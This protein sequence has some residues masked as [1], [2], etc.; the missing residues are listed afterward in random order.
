MPSL[1]YHPS[2]F[3]MVAVDTSI[4]KV[5]PG[6]T[7]SLQSALSGLPNQD[8]LVPPT[9][10]I[11]LLDAKNEIFLS[12]LQTLALRNL[13]VI[14]SVGKHIKHKSSSA[15]G[16]AKGVLDQSLDDQLVRDLVKHRVYLEKGVRP[17]EDRLKYQVDKVVR[18]ADD[19]ARAAQKA[20]SA[21]SSTTKKSSKTAQAAATGSDDSDSDSDPDSDEETG[22]A[23]IQANARSFM[24]VFT[25]PGAAT[26]AAP[27]T[28]ARQQ[29]MQEDGIY[30]PPRITATA[31]PTTEHK[32]AKEKRPMRSAT[33]DEY[34]A[35]ELSTA[36]AA[37]PSIGS[38]I[39]AGGRRDKS[40]RERKEEEERRV[41][42]ESNLV[43]LPKESKKDK[44]KKAHK[45]RGAYGGE[46]WRG[47]TD[48]VDR[49][50]RLTK[51]KIGSGGALERSRKRKAD[52]DGQRGDG[53]G[54]VDM[55]RD[56]ER[57]KKRT[58]RK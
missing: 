34:V 17:L 1:E 20:A 8:S 55:G 30:R 40:A 14:R 36:P 46:D 41:Y 16:D 51:K 18:A 57:R 33:I 25:S 26:S 39:A 4:A 38:T 24:H 29:A 49:I 28:N 9:D 19:E 37:E 7:Q 42:E 22:Q 43:R 50:D 32:E 21:S 3:K 10:G 11:T 58:M 56:F 44:A 54:G 35:N 53:A 15:N 31:M 12:Y 48:G 27:A 2:H 23:P 45:E 6:L 52:E 47:L 5:L 13:A